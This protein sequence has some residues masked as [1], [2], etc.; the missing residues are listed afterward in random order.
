MSLPTTFPLG[1]LFTTFTLL[2]RTKLEIIEDGEICGYQ[3]K[4]IRQV[5]TVLPQT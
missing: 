2:L 4:K 5:L 3:N 1:M